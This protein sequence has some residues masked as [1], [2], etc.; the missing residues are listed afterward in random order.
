MWQK[1]CERCGK[2]DFCFIMSMYNTQMICLDCKE[3][4]KKRSDYN[5]AVEE[6]AKAV[7]RGNYNFKGIGL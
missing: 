1:R 7:K 3:K 5:K 6:E 2:E 4:E